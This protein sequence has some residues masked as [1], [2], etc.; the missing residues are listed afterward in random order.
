[1]MKTA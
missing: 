1:M